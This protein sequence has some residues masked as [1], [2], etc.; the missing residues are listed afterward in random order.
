M[1]KANPIA[2]MMQISQ[3]VR[4][5]P[6]PSGAAG[7]MLGVMRSIVRAKNARFQ[8]G[9]RYFQLAIRCRSPGAKSVGR[10]TGKV[11]RRKGTLDLGWLDEGR[12]HASVA[13][14][15]R[16]PSRFT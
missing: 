1:S 2:A 3:A 10:I 6:D 15:Q 4:L 16:S 8:A 12:S 7:F 11:T 5:R 14:Y 9:I 13:A